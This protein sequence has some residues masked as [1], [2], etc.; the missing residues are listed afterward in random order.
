M[1]AFKPLIW[2]IYFVFMYLTL[3]KNYLLKSK[4]MPQIVNKN[5]IYNNTDQYFVI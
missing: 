5:S 2:S 4:V 3:T 1:S